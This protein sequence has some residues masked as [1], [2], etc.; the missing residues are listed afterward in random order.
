VNQQPEPTTT[1]VDPQTEETDESEAPLPSI[2]EQVAEQLGGVRGL[3]E[4]SIPVVVFVI[5]NV[6]W[7]LRPALITAMVSAV[8]LA[9]YR[10]ARRES[11]RHAVNGVFGVLVGVALAWRT[12]NAKDFYLPGIL[13]GIAYAVAMVISVLVRRPLVGW[14]W[15]V[16]MAGGAMSWRED[17]RLLRAFAWLTGLWAGFYVLKAALQIG[18][19]FAPQFSDDTKANALGVIKLALGYP[20]YLLLLAA[21]VWAVRRV[22][23]SAGP[24]QAA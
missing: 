24:T 3:I 2:S 18:V 9:G 12:G 6:L 15:S 21:T 14:I 16:V 13:I 23:R 19:Y 10:L 8:L 20:P 5:A 1:A 11:I 7:T 22:Q 4:S 17:P